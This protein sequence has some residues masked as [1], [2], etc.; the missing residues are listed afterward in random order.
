MRIVPWSWGCLGRCTCCVE[1]VLRSDGTWGSG[2]EA[3]RIVPKVNDCSVL[4]VLC[5]IFSS[6]GPILVLWVWQRFGIWLN[7]VSSNYDCLQSF[8]PL[9]GFC[10]TDH[11]LFYFFFQKIKRVLSV[12][13]VVHIFKPLL[14][15]TSEPAWSVWCISPRHCHSTLMPHPK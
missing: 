1:G 14:S 12:R 7:V 8:G 10:T 4:C 13:H 3:L 11:V 6:L 9:P 2:C 5:F 15:Y